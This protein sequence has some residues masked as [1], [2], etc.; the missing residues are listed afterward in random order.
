MP[1]VRMSFAEAR[2][3]ACKEK[4]DWPRI[5]AMTDEDIARQI[6]EDPDVAPDM[7]EALER[8]E[9]EVVWALDLEHV[10]SKTGLDQTAFAR[11]FGLPLKELIAWEAG[12]RV[13][14]RAIWMYLKLIERE[15]EIIGRRAEAIGRELF[16]KV[17]VAR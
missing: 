13:P 8:G 12:G 11:K 6:A 15:P 10:R 17:P 5:D 14:N 9:F 7:S 3:K 16:P 4:V 2:A 1:T